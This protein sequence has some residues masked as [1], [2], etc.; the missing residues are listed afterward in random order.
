MAERKVNLRYLQLGPEKIDLARYV[1]YKLSGNRMRMIVYL[2]NPDEKRFVEGDIAV[3]AAI[4]EIMQQSEARD[5]EFIGGRWV[6]L[7]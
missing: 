3:Q 2:K 4:E 5:E 6:E 7:E 1:N